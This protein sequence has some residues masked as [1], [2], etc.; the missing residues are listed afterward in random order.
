YAGRHGIAAAKRKFNIVGGG[1]ESVRAFQ[2]LIM[3]GWRTQLS[4]IAIKIGDWDAMSTKEKK[5]ADR[6]RLVLHGSLCAAS[7][8]FTGFRL[9][10]TENKEAA[11]AAFL[12]APADHAFWAPVSVWIKADGSQVRFPHLIWDRA[13]PGLV[14]VNGAGRRFVNEGTSYH[15][16]VRAMLR[17]HETVPTVPAFLIADR[18]FVD[19]WG[20]GLALPGGRPRSHLIRDGYLIEAA[21]IAELARKLDVPADA[22]G[23]SIAEMNQAAADGIDAGFGKG[24]SEYNRYYGDPAIAGNPCLGAIAEPPFYAVRVYPGDIGTASGLLTDT[25][26][27]VLD[28]NGEPIAG[29]YCCGSDMASIMGGHY[30]G[31]G[32]T[33]GPALTF[34][35]RIGRTI[36]GQQ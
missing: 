6:E 34:G 27:R 13:K 20:L 28:G 19:R 9:S 29:L 17:W 1:L 16:F 33:L 36:A 24:S 4:T 8:C 2:R 14:A 12:E 21:S 23:A 10:K 11:G 31:A 5:D 15:E 26:G 30:P 32:I 3:D 7:R 22:L 25:D 35:Y 18:P